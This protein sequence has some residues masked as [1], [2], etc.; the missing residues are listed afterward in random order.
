MDSVNSIAWLSRFNLLNVFLTSGS[1]K[2]QR[3]TNIVSI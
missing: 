3:Q 1:W 2:G